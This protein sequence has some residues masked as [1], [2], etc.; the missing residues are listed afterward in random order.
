MT[1]KTNAGAP[2]TLYDKM[3][4]AHVVDRKEDGTCIL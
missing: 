1:G 3:F 4:D 2:R